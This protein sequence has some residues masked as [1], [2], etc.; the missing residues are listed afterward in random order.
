MERLGWACIAA[1][2]ALVVCSFALVVGAALGTVN[3]AVHDDCPVLFKAA[4]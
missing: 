1:A 4:P 2:A 3:V